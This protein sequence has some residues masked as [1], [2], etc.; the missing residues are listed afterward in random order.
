MSKTLSTICLIGGSALAGYSLARLLARRTLPAPTVQAALTRGSESSAIPIVGDFLMIDD[1]I[2]VAYA[3]QELQDRPVVLLL[4]T[5]GG[6][7][8]PAMQIARAVRRHGRVTA[9]VPFFALS[10]GTFIALACQK[11]RMW[12][13]A[14]LGPIDPQLGWISAHSHIKLR[15]VKPVAEIEDRSILLSIEAQKALEETAAAARELEVP[16]RALGRLLSSVNSH[17]HPISAREAVNLGLRVEIE[18]PN[19]A[20]R[21][22]VAALIAERVR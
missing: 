17:S 12:P 16:E 19:A 22:R 2:E 4:H 3:L 13:D 1:A 11:I 10:A 7:W 21:R 14:S 8:F 18:E 6:P 20:A 15:E 5:L 9:L